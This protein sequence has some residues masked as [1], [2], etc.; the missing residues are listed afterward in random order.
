MRLTADTVR[1]IWDGI[2]MPWDE[3]FR[4]D[5]KTYANNIERTIA[6]QVHGIYTT[7]TTG[8]FYAIEYEEFCT[9]VDIQAD[10]CGK[11]NMP[12][13]IGCCSD[14][15][16]K[17]IKLLEYAA[18]K[19]QV[20]GAQ[21]VIPYWMEVEDC[22]LLQFFK[23]IYTACPDMPLIHYNNPEAKRFLFGEDYLKIMEVAP[24]LIGI[25][26]AQAGAHF[27]Q[28]QDSMA[29]TPN[30]SYLVAECLLV[31][32]MQLGARGSCSSLVATNPKFT[33][34]MYAKA[35][36]GKWDEAIKMQQHASKFFADA[37]AFI[38]ARG[39]STCDSVFD[40]GLSVASGF[41]LG[42]QRCRAP[43]TGW[44]NETVQAMSDWLK[45]NYS[46]FVNS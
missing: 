39:E 35:E 36:A 26:F 23:D 45:S 40:K 42:H 31:S 16:A 32:A 37:E 3:H 11:A 46:E 22:Q 27:A 17:T 10:L 1:G 21:I 19:S 44:S 4:F 34:D 28:L 6:A 38:E 14:A 5:E 7:G 41:I 43:Y 12:L 33:L 25:K 15:T 2:T 13:Q 24:S 29:M 9:M 30:L 8:E 18:G 20:G